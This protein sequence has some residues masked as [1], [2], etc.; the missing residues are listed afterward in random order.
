MRPLL[1]PQVDGLAFL[2]RRGWRGALF[3]EPGLGKTRLALEI[4]KRARRTLVLAPP[5]PCEFVWPD[6]H[7]EWASDIRFDVV[8]GQVPAGE[9]YRRLIKDPPDVAVMNYQL[10]HW[11]YDVVRTKRKLP[12]DCLI[13]DESGEAKNHDSVTFR[14][15]KSIEHLFDAVI[16]MNGTPAE[17]SLHDVWSQLYL[18]DRGEALGPRI[19]VFRERYFS[20]VLRDKYVSWK[21]TRPAELRLAAAPLCFVRRTA[22]CVDMPPIAFRDVKFKLDRAERKAYDTVKEDHILPVDEPVP[23]ENA[24]VALDKLRQI[25][26]GFVYDEARVARSLG[27]SKLEALT[28]AIEEYS[29]QPVLVGYWYRGSMEQIKEFTKEDIPTINRH[30]SSVEKRAIL[31]DWKHGRL[32]W[33]LGQVSTVAKGLNM[34]SPGKAGVCFYD[35]PWSH[36]LHWQFIRRVWRLGQTGSVM[37]RRLI[38]DRTVESY[39]AVKLKK[40]QQDEEDLMSTILEEE[41][42]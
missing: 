6:Q 17:N 31:N 18:V 28:E 4:A 24:G 40:K 2:R 21:C 14:V 20:P 41:I 1:H 11:L 19:G 36:G 9:R 5:N 29:G 13:L 42:L 23:L 34:Q 35:M 3:M 15:L 25:T 27:T 37:V 33:L 7:R 22:D 32:K 38:A 12:Y 39:V 30:T 10:L 16:P 8:T 26:S